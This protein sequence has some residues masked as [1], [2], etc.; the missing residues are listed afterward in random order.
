MLSKREGFSHSRESSGTSRSLSPEGATMAT[1]QQESS[2]PT[3][4]GWIKE[5]SSD[6][7]SIMINSLTGDRVGCCVKLRLVYWYFIC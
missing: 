5:R 1:S 4:A 2:T 3:P 7:E 6:G